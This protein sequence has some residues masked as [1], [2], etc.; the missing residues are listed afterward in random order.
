[1]SQPTHRITNGNANG[2]VAIM[3][4]LGTVC[5]SLFLL[6]RYLSIEEIR[7]VTDSA[8]RQENALL[9]T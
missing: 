4:Y 5:R 1:M 3:E 9:S 2:F 7:N 8:V 6:E